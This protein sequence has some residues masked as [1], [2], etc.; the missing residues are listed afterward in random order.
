MDNAYSFI[1]IG[2][3][4][5]EVGGLTDGLHAATKVI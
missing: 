5:W 3:F 2:M 4:Y 1:Q